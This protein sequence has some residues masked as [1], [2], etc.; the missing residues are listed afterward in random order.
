[1]TRASIG[2]PGATKRC[3]KAVPDQRQKML[4]LAGI[5]EAGKEGAGVAVMEHLHS[6]NEIARTP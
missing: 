3:A 1:M 5:V 4:F 2:V 6:F